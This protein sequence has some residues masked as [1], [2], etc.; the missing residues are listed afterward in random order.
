MK[1]LV[2]SCMMIFASIG[3]SAQILYR[4]SGNGAK[5]ESYL[6]GTHHFAP[7]KI[8]KDIKGWDAALAGVEA[9]YSEIDKKDVDLSKVEKLTGELAVAPSDSTLSKVLTPDEYQLLDQILKKYTNNTAGAKDVNEATPAFIETQLL[10]MQ[11]MQAFPDYAPDDQ[12]DMKIQKKA[13]KLKKATGGLESMEAQLRVLL[14]GSIAAQAESLKRM[15][16]QDM[17]SLLLHKRLA[18]LYAAQDIDAFWALMN[19]PMLGSTPDE[20]ERLIYSRNDDWM[21]SIPALMAERPVMFVVGLGHLP[22]D[23]GLISQLKKA[24]YEVTPVK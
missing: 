22:G 5:G 12:I 14:G 21:T 2:L 9:V 13:K 8:L 15:L 7:S 3:A 16:S 4:V 24:G 10:A 11:A 20:M 1:E 23:R 17:Y 18:D 19:D 6:L